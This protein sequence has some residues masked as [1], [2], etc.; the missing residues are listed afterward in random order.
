MDHIDV[1]IVLTDR[2]AVDCDYKAE[3]SGGLRRLL[4][5]VIFVKQKIIGFDKD[6]EGGWRARLECGHYQHVRHDPP[7]NIR[8]WVLTESGRRNKIGAVLECRKCDE[9]SPADF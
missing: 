3:H 9:D 2:G 1:N 4:A 5:M 8:E 6:D 7:L